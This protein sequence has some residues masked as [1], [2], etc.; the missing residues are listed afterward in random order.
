MTI[1]IG[2]VNF[3]YGTVI[4]EEGK[5]PGE[6]NFL[7]EIGDVTIKLR[8]RGEPARVILE[9]MR[10]AMPVTSVTFRHDE[11]GQLHKEEHR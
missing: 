1:R 10:A 11:S 2:F 9:A 4:L 3:E 5:N 7:V 6:L 8:Q